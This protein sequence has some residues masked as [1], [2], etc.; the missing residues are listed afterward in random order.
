MPDDEF[1]FSELNTQCALINLYKQC[2]VI[3]MEN[4][5]V[6]LSQRGK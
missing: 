6:F 3:R 4:G 2:T 5:S 1:K